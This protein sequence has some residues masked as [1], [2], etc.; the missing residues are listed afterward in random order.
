MDVQVQGGK[1]NA[2]S[3]V[4]DTATT[5]TTKTFLFN[6]EQMATKS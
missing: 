6:I 2:Q 1:C 5:C 3:E 4:V